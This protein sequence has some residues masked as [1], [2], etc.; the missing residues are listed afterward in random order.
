M[1]IPSFRKNKKHIPYFISFIILIHHYIKH[2][3]DKKAFINKVFQIKDIKNHETWVL[4][5]IGVGIGMAICN[6]NIKNY[7]NNEIHI[8]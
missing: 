7:V 8:F 4:F 5:F 1:N 2:S 6:I 3:T